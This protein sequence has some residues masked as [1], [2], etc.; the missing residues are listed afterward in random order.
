M[1]DNR[2]KLIFNNNK[3]NIT[4]Y[5]DEDNNIVNNIIETYFDTASIYEF[6]DVDKLRDVP[7]NPIITIVKKENIYSIGKV[8]NYS[9]VTD[10]FIT[11][12]FNSYYYV[13]GGRF[14]KI[15]N[16]IIEFIKNKNGVINE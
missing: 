1:S 14:T 4:F 7:F 11:L 12:N 9:S 16:E 15:K 3:E 5:I 6:L 13:R 2:F 8:S 10:Y